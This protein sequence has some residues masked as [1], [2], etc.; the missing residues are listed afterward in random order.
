M[1]EGQTVYYVDATTEGKLIRGCMV[2][3]RQHPDWRAVGPVKRIGT[4]TG[5]LLSQRMEKDTPDG[6]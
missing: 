2:F 4:P 5:K 1:N 6:T 3:A